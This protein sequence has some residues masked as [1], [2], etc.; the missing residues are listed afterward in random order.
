[1]SHLRM[2]EL[3][4]LTGMGARTAR[5]MKIRNGRLTSTRRTIASM[6]GLGQIAADDSPCGPKPGLGPGEYAQCCPDLGWVIYDAYESSYGLC[7]RA[8][9]SASGDDTTSDPS[10]PL[11]RVDE[12]KRQIDARRAEFEDRQHQQKLAEM[13]LRMA[14]TRMS[15]IEAQRQAQIQAEQ[16]AEAARVKAAA[17]ARQREQTNK[18]LGW[19]AAALIAAKALALF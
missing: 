18:V 13:Q 15:A 17:D 16:A 3:S 19:G 2:E 12:L 9:G 5:F 7:E 10:S 14:L 1:M 4:C 11:A 6:S 8:R